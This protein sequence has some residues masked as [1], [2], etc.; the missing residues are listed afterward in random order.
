M[1]KGYEEMRDKFARTM[2]MKA[3]K[4]KAARIWNA[5]HPGNPVGRG[6]GGRRRKRKPAKRKRTMMPGRERVGR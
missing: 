3:A 2:G 6:E 1:P 4:A 5:S